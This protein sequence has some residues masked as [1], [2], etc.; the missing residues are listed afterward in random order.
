LD[1]LRYRLAAILWLA[2]VAL[3]AAFPAADAAT[4][5]DENEAQ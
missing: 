1:N 5:H 2:G 3:F 4:A